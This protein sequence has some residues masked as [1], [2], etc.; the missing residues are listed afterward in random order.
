MVVQNAL[1]REQAYLS[2]L[3][4]QAKDAHPDRLY[5]VSLFFMCTFRQPV[6]QIRNWRSSV[7]EPTALSTEDNTAPPDMSSP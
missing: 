5:E 4:S 6:D 7:K 3:A 1:S 2:S